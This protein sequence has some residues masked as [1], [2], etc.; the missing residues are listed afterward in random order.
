MNNME[1]PVSKGVE[2]EEQEGIMSIVSK[3]QDAEGTLIQLKNDQETLRQA[4][5]RGD[6]S[7]LLA[8]IESKIREVIQ[9]IASLQDQKMALIKR[10][11]ARYMRSASNEPSSED[12][13][14]TALRVTGEAQEADKLDARRNK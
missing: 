6:K 12:A 1:N 8:E 10:G 5:E 4:P 9:K 3:I 2:G 13:F 14:D 11:D 7:S